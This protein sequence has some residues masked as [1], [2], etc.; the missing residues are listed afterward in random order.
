M[1][2]HDYGNIET[3][4]LVDFI[5]RKIFYSQNLRPFWFRSLVWYVKNFNK[6]HRTC[7]PQNIYLQ[8][9]FVCLWKLEVEYR[10]FYFWLFGIFS[11]QPFWKCAR[12]GSVSSNLH[13]I[14]DAYYL[15]FKIHTY[16]LLLI[17]MLWHRQAIFESKGDKLSSSAESRIRTQGVSET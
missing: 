7:H 5:P 2:W 9:N 1:F 12:R 10:N 15:G 8:A 3:D 4:I 17:S 13:L 11:G 16:L 6:Y 14:V